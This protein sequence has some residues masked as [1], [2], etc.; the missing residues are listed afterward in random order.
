LLTGLLWFAAQALPWVAMREAAWQRIGWMVM[1][2]AASAALYFGALWGAG[3]RLKAF[4]K[5]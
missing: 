3:L 4:L 5:R 2:M 1:V